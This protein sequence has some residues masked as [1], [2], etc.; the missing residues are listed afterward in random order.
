MNAKKK[1]KYIEKKKKKTCLLHSRNFTAGL[2]ALAVARRERA[3]SERT[4]SH[5]CLLLCVDEPADAAVRSKNARRFFFAAGS[6]KPPK[7]V[8]VGRLHRSMHSTRPLDA[9][10]MPR[11]HEIFARGPPNRFQLEAE[12]RLRC[13]IH[14]HQTTGRRSLDASPT[15]LTSRTWSTEPESATTSHAGKSLLE[16]TE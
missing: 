11:G 8:R 4:H 3:V 12:N 5:A 9:V 16:S 6:S 1:I 7:S 13:R 14:G 2:A 10:E 15:S